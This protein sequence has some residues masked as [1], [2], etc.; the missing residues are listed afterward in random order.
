MTAVMTA[1]MAMHY[2]INGAEPVDERSMQSFYD[3]FGPF[4]ES[5]ISAVTAA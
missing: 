2:Q 1:V 5:H 3:T 4:G